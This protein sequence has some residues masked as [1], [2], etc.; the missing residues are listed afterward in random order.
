MSLPKAART[1][2]SA[3]NSSSGTGRCYRQSRLGRRTPD[4]RITRETFLS[5]TR[6]TSTDRASGSTTRTP[7]PGRT[8]IGIPRGIPGAALVSRRPSPDQAPLR[9]AT[10]WASHASGMSLTPWHGHCSFDGAA[11]WL[12]PDAW[13][14]WPR[15]EAVSGEHRARRF[16]A[17]RKCQWLRTLNRTSSDA[18]A[19]WI[20][21]KGAMVFRSRGSPSE[22][23]LVRFQG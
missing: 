8:R 11:T 15:R 14:S 18:G 10:D 9:S 16:K 19:D 23:C 20:T 4:L 12:Q 3:G 22:R 5:P 1:E 13:G 6:S 2:P 7:A 21:Y 17:G